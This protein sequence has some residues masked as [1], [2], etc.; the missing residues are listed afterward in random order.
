[1]SSQDAT[2]SSR[3]RYDVARDLA[4]ACPAAC[5]SEIALTGS[6]SRGVADGDSDIEVNFWS[7]SLPSDEERD[8]WLR[9]VGAIEIVHDTEAIADG[10]IWSACQY[11]GLRIEAGWQTVAAQQRLLTAILEGAILDHDRLIIA[12]VVRH[13]VPLRTGGILASWQTQLAEYPEVLRRRLIATAVKQWHSAPFLWALAARHEHVALTSRLLRHVEILL[14]LL[15]ALNREWE[16]DWKWA[17]YGARGLAIVPDRFQDRSDAVFF[18][19]TPEERI[20]A[21][22]ELI[23]D[24]LR[25]LPGTDDV[26]QARRAIGASIDHRTP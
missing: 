4:A 22:L 20:A 16:P 2:P 26:A 1:M 15:F 6:A 10:S 21:L 19:P 8:G 17:R 14:R 3:A 23:A 18:A 13:A 25:L 9:E 24:T 5:G 12:E 11:Q 7:E